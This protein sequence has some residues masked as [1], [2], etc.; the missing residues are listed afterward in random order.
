MEGQEDHSFYCTAAALISPSNPY[1]CTCAA[2]LLLG[3]HLHVCTCNL[4]LRCRRAASCSSA[5]A[6]EA[7]RRLDRQPLRAQLLPTTLQLRPA[8]KSIG[9]FTLLSV[10]STKYLDASI[11]IFLPTDILSLRFLSTLPSGHLII[12]VSTLDWTYS[13]SLWL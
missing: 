4:Q 8:R 10:R 6:Q 12:L 13:W 5:R 7:G 3:L 11:P 1:C 9:S 2:R